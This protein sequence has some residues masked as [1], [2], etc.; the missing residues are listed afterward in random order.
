[1]TKYIPLHV[2]CTIPRQ[3]QTLNSYNPQTGTNRAYVLG[4]NSRP[5]LEKIGG[6]E[7][8]PPATITNYN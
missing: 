3:V 1:M 6:L 4:T 7:I 8:A 5:S 2:V